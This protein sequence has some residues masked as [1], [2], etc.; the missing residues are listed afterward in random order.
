MPG[1]AQ[2][3][4]G[5]FVSPM[6]KPRYLV[7]FSGHRANFSEPAVRA[8]LRVALA[9]LQQR[10]AACGGRVELYASAAEGSDVVCLDVAQELGMPVH[11]LLPLPE[12]EFAKDFSSPEAWGR[13]KAHLDLA[14]KSP[15][16]SSVETVEG[17][18]TRP[19]CYFDQG[20]LMLEA[21]DV[22]IVVWNGQPPR[23]LGG[24]AQMVAQARAT[25]IPVLHI[26]PQDGSAAKDAGFDE[27]I[28]KD[29]IMDELNGIAKAN[30]GVAGQEVA[31]PEELQRALD[32][33]AVG[34]AEKL[35]PSR[36]RIILIHGLATF[37]AALVTF[38][39]MD[40]AALW[41]RY[42]WV[43]SLTELALVCVALW[44]NLRLRRRQ[45][46]ER[47][48]RCR[49]ACELVRGLRTSVPLVNPLHPTMSR[50]DE[51]WRR[52]VLSA[53]LLIQA[54]HAGGSLK[55]QR[56]TYLSER[57]SETH[58]DGQIRHYLKMNPGDLRWWGFAG[59]LG[60]W[61]ARLAPPFVAASVLNKLS[62]I[63]HSPDGWGL[64]YEFMTW[65]AVGF[66]P[67]ALPLVAG[68]ATGLRHTLDAGRRKLR[69]P[70]MVRRLRAIRDSLQ[71]L[72]TDV[73]IRRAVACS[74]DI[75]Q[76]ELRE[77]R[78]A[79]SSSAGR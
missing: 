68:V 35:R 31:G 37:L 10:A 78:L 33:I 73:T 30:E 65:I 9:D 50:H 53:G 55:A 2:T 40:K 6:L 38:K 36:M 44:M 16:P 32:Q 70:Q 17:H 79:A 51:E 60:D 29:A 3:H 8:A 43:I 67:I 72:E 15:G 48:I 58:P 71:G 18:G 11:I 28:G 76:D 66:L 61:C 7:G 22:L 54:H 42:K 19:D 46:Q 34:E 62:K 39:V 41:E 45:V 20:I 63:W 12:E 23:G 69:Y 77:W 56:D 74:E 14:A 75:L 25:G 13:A 49:F 57:L 59:G 64:E 52:F 24:T 4:E 26:D 21:V 1:L 47:W 27:A 5:C